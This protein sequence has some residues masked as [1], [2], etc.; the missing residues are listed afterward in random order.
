MRIGTLRVRTTPSGVGPG[1]GV[2]VATGEGGGVALA[3][4]V[5]VEGWVG[6]SVGVD[7]AVG[8]VATEAGVRVALGARSSD[9]VSMI[10][11]EGLMLAVPGIALGLLG[12]LWV[13]ESI[14]V[15]LYRVS[16]TDPTSIAFTGLALVAATMLASYVPAR[17]AA[18]FDVV[19]A[20]RGE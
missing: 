4:G 8:V 10:L 20:L 2:A 12:A 19:R 9:V 1:V 14:A 15:L 5:G 6:V 13:S 16:P 11:R 17:R 7:D 18:R 3:V